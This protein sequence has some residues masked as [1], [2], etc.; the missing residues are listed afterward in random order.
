MKSSLN[1]K[2]QAATMKFAK[3]LVED[4]LNCLQLTHWGNEMESEIELGPE[5]LDDDEK[6]FIT[7]YRL[8]VELLGGPPSREELRDYLESKRE[9]R[10]ANASYDNEPFAPGDP[11]WIRHADCRCGVETEQ[12][13]HGCT[14]NGHL[15]KG[16]LCTCQGF[17]CSECGRLLDVKGWCCK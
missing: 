6:S 15:W 7:G 17:E 14:S 4:G 13:L 1:E 12:W 9:Q 2:Q 10:D 8:A 11:S 16:H 5:E 3:E